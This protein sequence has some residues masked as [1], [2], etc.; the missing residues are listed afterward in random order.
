LVSKEPNLGSAWK[1]K[2]GF[3]SLRK[4]R[5]RKP[6]F[7]V[8]LGLEFSSL[9]SAEVRLAVWAHEPGPTILQ[10]CFL[11]PKAGS[12]RVRLAP[13][14]AH[15]LHYVKFGVVDD[16]ERLDLRRWAQIKFFLPPSFLRCNSKRNRG[17]R[18]LA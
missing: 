4:V 15:E 14:R 17:F 9:G 7:L 11:K 10:F 18:N 16:P 2:R 3:G 5:L 13:P 1:L 6:G 12:A 8:N